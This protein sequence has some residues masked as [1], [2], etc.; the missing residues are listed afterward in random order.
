M[1]ERFKFFRPKRPRKHRPGPE[2]H[3]AYGGKKYWAATRKRILVR[4]NWQCQHCG[5]V[6]SMP[7]EAQCDHKKPKAIGG[8][9]SDENLQ[10]LCL[11]CHSKKTRAE[12][13]AGL[14]KPLQPE[15]HS[16]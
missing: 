7:G 2:F 6:C 11:P 8:D 3:V 12:Q 10:T 4:D 5:R 14:L 9:D 16:R 13:M 1:P 15:G